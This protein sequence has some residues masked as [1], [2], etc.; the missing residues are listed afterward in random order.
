VLLTAIVRNAQGGA[1]MIVQ[2]VR[3]RRSDRSLKQ[4]TRGLLSTKRCECERTIL[5]SDYCG[6]DCGGSGV[7]GVVSARYGA[8][9]WR[10]A[11]EA[12]ST[13]A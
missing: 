7:A 4:K 3:T 12:A 1:S 6:G 8:Q 13:S 2:G 5:F 11:G 9:T 10:L